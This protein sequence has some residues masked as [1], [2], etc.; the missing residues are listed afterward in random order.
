MRLERFATVL[1]QQGRAELEETIERMRELLRFRVVWNVNTTARGGG[2]AEMLQSMV[3]YARGAGVDWRWVVIAGE[4]QFFRVTKRIH[5]W[6]HGDP[7]DGGDLDRAARSAYETALLFNGAALRELVR[8]GDI[9]VLHD[10][11]TAGLIPAL[12]GSGV[13]LV[14]RAHIGL[15]QPN[16][17]ARSAWLFLLP[18]VEPAEAYVFSR[19]AHVWSYLDGSRTRVIAPSIDAFSPKNQDLEPAT[20]DAIL[21]AAHIF[22]GTNGA[23]PVFERQD[24]SPGRVDRHAEMLGGPALDPELPIVCQVSRW[25]RLKDPV[26]VM[27]GFVSQVLSN[28][29]AQLLLAG[30]STREVA[31]DPEGAEVLEQVLRAWQELPERARARVGLACLP[32]VDGE[33]NAA[34]VNAL[35]RRSDVIVQKSLAEGFGLTVSEAMWKARPVVA[36]AVGGIQDQIEDGRSGV[37]IPDPSDLDTFGR[38]VDG[39]LG[40]HAGAESIGARARVRVRDHFLSTRDLRQWT[41]LF[42]AL[43]ATGRVPRDPLPEVAGN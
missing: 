7:G 4:Q 37:L 15:D 10:P 11:Q 19:P 8:E 43:L 38:R 39:L 21:R 6:L 9:V 26:G 35:Q 25:D 12:E 28:R 29:D 36:S 23:A 3:A 14:W 13:H 2:V 20:V 42:E 1:D 34:I 16:E 27:H 18:Y 24:G 32:M 22:A 40:D 5:N 31:D 17:L 30:P 33:E 41:D